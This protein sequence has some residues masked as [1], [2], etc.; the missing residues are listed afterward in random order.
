MGVL[1]AVSGI[2]RI[3][4]AIASET[5]YVFMMSNHHFLSMIVEFSIVRKE[6]NYSFFFGPAKIKKKTY[7][8]KKR[9]KF[10]L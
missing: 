2:E 8:Q 5:T 4:N 3:G 6:V 7:S 10:Y 9:I 1:E